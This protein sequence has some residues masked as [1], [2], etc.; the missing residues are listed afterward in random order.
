M[1]MC[2][3]EQAFY[4]T[5]DPEVIIGRELTLYKFKYK[6]QPFEL[7]HNQLLSSDAFNLKC[8][9]K[10]LPAVDF[11]IGWKPFL[12]EILK[13]ATIIDETEYA[14]YVSIAKEYCQYLLTSG[15]Y[16]EAEF[17]DSIVERKDGSCHYP[18]ES[19]KADIEDLHL[20]IGFKLL[21][22]ILE[23]HGVKKTWVLGLDIE[24]ICGKDVYVWNFD[25][26]KLKEFG[27][28]YLEWKDLPP[29]IMTN[30]MRG[31]FDPS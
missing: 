21:E 2:E 18:V 13:K 29:F 1:L 20:D 10:G 7:R 8:L 4:S 19:V 17:E 9:S 31:L 22:R 15:I 12:N 11:G 16:E 3:A 6:D 26:V 5:K 30:S 28:G 14:P 24:T 23:K 27:A 25:L